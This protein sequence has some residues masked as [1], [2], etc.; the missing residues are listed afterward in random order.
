MIY[1]AGGMGMA[2]P[3]RSL[4]PVG[5]RTAVQSAT[6]KPGMEIVIEGNERLMPGM[7]I[8]PTTKAPAAAPGGGH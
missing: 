8:A 2:A 6:L 7:P 3:V 4:F 5:D 1:N